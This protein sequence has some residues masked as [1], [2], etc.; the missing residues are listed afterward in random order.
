MHVFSLLC[1]L[2]F[3]FTTLKVFLFIITKARL[4]SKNSKNIVRV[5]EILCFPL[6]RLS[7]S[8]ELLT[9]IAVYD[10]SFT[11]RNEQ[12]YSTVCYDCVIVSRHIVVDWMNGTTETLFW[13]DIYE[14]NK[15]RSRANRKKRSMK[16]KCTFSVV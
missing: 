8:I 7:T 5:I 12:C 13:M 14:K 4:E 11:E 15:S 6:W 10:E 16:E 2:H 3:L 1:Q 9:A